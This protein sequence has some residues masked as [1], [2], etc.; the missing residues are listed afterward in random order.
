MSV[1]EIWMLSTP[2]LA[3]GKGWV[4]FSLLQKGYMSSFIFLLQTIL[5]FMLDNLFK[6]YVFANAVL[7]I[8]HTL[9]FLLSGFKKNPVLINIKKIN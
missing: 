9:T 6:M 8:V 7:F 3:P 2:F 4:A 5:N 1:L